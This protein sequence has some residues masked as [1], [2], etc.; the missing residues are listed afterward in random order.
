[1]RRERYKGQIVVARLYKVRTQ[2]IWHASVFLD[3][4]VKGNWEEIPIAPELKGQV[5]ASEESALATALDYGRSYVDA[6]H[7]PSDNAA[8]EISLKLTLKRSRSALARHSTAM[9][10]TSDPSAV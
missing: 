9:S 5:F 7:A 6:F 8:P 10:V 3:R 4:L 2:P 1:M